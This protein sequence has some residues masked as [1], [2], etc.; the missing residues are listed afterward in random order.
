MLGNLTTKPLWCL[1]LS[2]FLFVTS[3]AQAKPADDKDHHVTLQLRWFHQYQFAGYYVARE[4]GYYDAAG[5]KVEIIEGRPGIDPVEEVVSGRASFGVDN[6]GLAW[7][8][9]RGEPVK[10]VAAIF[11]KSALRFLVIGDNQIS[12]QALSGKSI[13][14]LPGYGSLALVALLKQQNVLDSIVR[15][16]SSHNISDLIERKVFAFNGYASNEPYE[17]EN[18]KVPFALIDP[19][20]YG[21]QFYSDILFTSDEL[22]L[23]DPKLVDDFRAA[24]LKGWKYA[25]DF[26]EQT[27]PIVQKY[28]PD[29]SK[30]HLRFEANIVRQHTISDFVEIGHMS[31]ER[32]RKIQ[33]ILIDI[34]LIPNDQKIV[35]SELLHKPFEQQK[36]WSRYI[37]YMVVAALVITVLSVGLYVFYCRSRRLEKEIEKT[38]AVEAELFQ[39]ATHDP[40][41]QL[42]NRLLLIDRLQL[43]LMD[44]NRTGYNTVL[45]FIDLD[46]FKAVNDECGHQKGDQLLKKAACNMQAEVRASCTLARYGGDEFVYL[47][48]GVS[49][50]EARII[51]QRLINAVKRAS[52]ELD[53]TQ[54]VSASIGVVIIKKAIGMSP[55]EAIV[56]ADAVMYAS[57][58]KGKGGFEIEVIGGSS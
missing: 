32:W 53:L 33:D 19:S 15:V 12:P 7:A 18:A 31:L 4:L 42:P 9:S 1:A 20:D 11:Q 37:E 41:T 10:A 28:A 29:K 58:K 36:N 3:Q 27:I 23:T 46:N 16:E 47:G 49:T 24:T 43:A 25:L 13:M 55:D 45:A 48:R 57:K 30:S 35:V 50:E 34:G 21:I 52:S 39:V 26:P 54:K 56:K 6:S 22:S 8:R 2:A 38:K 5:I 40:L 51:A 44:T 14:L 17:L